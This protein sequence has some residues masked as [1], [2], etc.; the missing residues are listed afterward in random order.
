MITNTIIVITVVLIVGL[1][2]YTQIR[3]AKK[4]SSSCGCGCGCGSV[5]NSPEESSSC[6]NAKKLE[7]SIE[8]MHCGHCQKSVSEALNSLDG[9]SATVDLENN[10]AN[11]ELSKDVPE[12]DLIEAVS[13]KGFEVT[14]VKTV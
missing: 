3:K 12:A 9:V 7:L 8:G 1:A 2:V 4:G 13:A 5:K 10:C 14:A 6:S 11:V